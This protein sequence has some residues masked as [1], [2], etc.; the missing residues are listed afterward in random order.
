M[1]EMPVTQGILNLALEHARGRRITDIYL[2]VGR[3]SPIVPDSVSLFFEYLSQGTLAEGARLHFEIVPI[4]MTCQDCLRKVDLEEWGDERGPLV[5]AK[6]LA[7]GCTCGSKNLRVTGG[8]KFGLVS[9]DVEE[10]A[11]DEGRCAGENSKP[12][13]PQ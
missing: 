3:M 11:S 13:R 10:P 7:R 1:H 4:E 12:E 5:M 9:L 6:A 8:V 2:Q